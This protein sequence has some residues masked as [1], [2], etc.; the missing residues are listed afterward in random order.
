MN[1]EV[2]VQTKTDIRVSFDFYCRLNRGYQTNGRTCLVSA[3]LLNCEGIWGPLQNSYCSGF[4]RKGF[5]D[6][7]TTICANVGCWKADQRI[8]RS[9]NGEVFEH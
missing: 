8:M 7:H 5:L 6:R 3:T 2:A 4:G 9:F 1:P